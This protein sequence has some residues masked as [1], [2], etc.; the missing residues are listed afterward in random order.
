MTYPINSAAATVYRYIKTRLEENLTVTP[1]DLVDQGFCTDDLAL[2]LL[3]KLITG[4]RISLPPHDWDGGVLR[5]RAVL[6]N[7]S[8]STT[9]TAFT[10]P[11]GVWESATGNWSVGTPSLPTNTETEKAIEKVVSEK[12]VEPK[13]LTIDSVILPERIKR[14]IR[15]AISQVENQKLIFDD[16]GFSEVFEKGTAI[17]LL[18]YG[19]PG[20]GKTLAAQAIAEEL[21]MDLKIYGTAEIQSSEPGGAERTMK[22]IFKEAMDLITGKKRQRVILFDECDSLLTSRN[23]VGV[24][25]GAQINTLLSEIERYAG[26]IIF[27]TNRLGKLDEA[28]ERRLTAKIE[29]P[30][31]EQEARELIW[32]RLVPK[33]APIDKKVNFKKLA[34]IPIAG[35]NIKNVV[36]NSARGAAFDKSKTIQVKHFK[37]A[38]EKEIE[39][40]EGFNNAVNADGYE[41]QDEMVQTHGG[42]KIKSG[43]ETKEISKEG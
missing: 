19:L 6:G 11:I 9:A 5:P 3:D 29:F 22:R 10:F 36:L 12:K 31:P 33:K 35:G 26:I 16:W 8:D 43:F 40:M 7:L 32:K 41:P 24:I 25:L 37:E 21:G 28:L 42:L 18:F 1:A 34:A 30:F 4:N 17:S 39:G 20:T 27:T 15:S 14:Q 2:P 13:K 38:L 23:K